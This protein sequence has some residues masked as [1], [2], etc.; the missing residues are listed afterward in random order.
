MGTLEG[1]AALVTG[2][3]RGIGRAIAAK[4][5]AE[6]AS[7]LASDID[8]EPLDE[9]VQQVASA[10]GRALPLVGD[11]AEVDF[12][13]RTHTLE[14]RGRRPPV[15]VGAESVE[16]FFKEHTWG[17]GSTPEGDRVTYQVEHPIWRVFE[18]EPG[19]L[20]LDW[21]FGELYG[22]PWQVLDGLEPSYVAF[23]E[24]SEIAVYPRE[25]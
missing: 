17:F 5:A 16:H 11:V 13:E 7:V 10:G 4:L 20:Q 24:G 22:Q 15:E 14:I 18:V 8:A 19:S 25:S 12:G 21:Y 6:G 1:R 2:A 3:G 23:A 9:T